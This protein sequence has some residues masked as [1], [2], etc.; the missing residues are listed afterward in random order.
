MGKKRPRKAEKMK[1]KQQITKKLLWRRRRQM[2]SIK[3]MHKNDDVRNTVECND[4]K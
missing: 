4:V 3:Q 2:V 1:K